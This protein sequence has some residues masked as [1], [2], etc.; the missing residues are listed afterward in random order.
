MTGQDVNPFQSLVMVATV[1][2]RK[3]LLMRRRGLARKIAARHGVVESYV[4]HVIAGRKRSRAIEVEFARAVGMRV[5][6][7]FPKRTAHARRVPISGRVN[8]R[9]ATGT[10][11]SG[12]PPAASSTS[13][14]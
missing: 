7:L 6:D 8:E 10:P 11:V 12:R 1:E 2:L 14:V 5:D 4:S 3:L 13:E 9:A